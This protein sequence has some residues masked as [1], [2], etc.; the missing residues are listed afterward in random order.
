M[1]NDNS[2]NGANH[3][4]TTTQRAGPIPELFCEGMPHVLAFAGHACDSNV[5]AA[6]L[7]EANV[8]TLGSTRGGARSNTSQLD[9]L[10]ADGPRMKWQGD[11]ARA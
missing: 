1:A 5:I 7:S 2:K 11:C 9:L 8:E 6:K 4:P 3:G 10:S